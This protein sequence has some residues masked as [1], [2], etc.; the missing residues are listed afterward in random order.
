MLGLTNGVKSH[1][2]SNA[3]KAPLLSPLKAF[4][5]KPAAKFQNSRL[6]HQAADLEPALVACI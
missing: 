5:G 4:H 2:A 1:L 3:F 6:K